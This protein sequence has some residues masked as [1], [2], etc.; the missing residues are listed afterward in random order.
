MLVKNN[1]L[2][3][4]RKNLPSQQLK[5]L[6]LRSSDG[7]KCLLLK[8]VQGKGPRGLSKWRHLSFRPW[9]TQQSGTSVPTGTHM[10]RFALVYACLVHALCEGGGNKHAV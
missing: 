1:N 2:I 3:T 5:V 4:P 8:P 7:D 6:T 10:P 9:K